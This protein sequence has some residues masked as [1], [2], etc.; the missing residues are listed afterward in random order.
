MT[1]LLAIVLVSSLGCSRQKEKTVASAPPCEA[2]GKPIVVGQE[3]VLLTGEG[4]KH[5]FR[6]VHC[7]LVKQAAEYPDSSFRTASAE[8]GKEIL[9]MRNEGGWSTLPKET[10]FLI[11]PETENECFGRHQ[12][13]SGEEEL[14]SYLRSRPNLSEFKPKTYTILDIDEMLPAGL[15]KDDS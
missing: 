12:A 15:P 3:V 9:V 14:Q 11:L 2:C 13:F 1:I 7:A 8:T 6:C 10:V 4:E 5:V